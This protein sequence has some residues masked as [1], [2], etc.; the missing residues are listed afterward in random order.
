M[1]R[2]NF[3]GWLLHEDN[4]IDPFR[5]KVGLDRIRGKNINIAISMNGMDYEPVGNIII[6]HDC[7]HPCGIEVA[8]GTTT[9]AKV[10]RK[11]SHVLDAF[12]LPTLD[13]FGE[14]E[15]VRCWK[16]VAVT[17][18]HMLRE[19]LSVT[20]QHNRSRLLRN[21]I[22]IFQKSPITQQLGVEGVREVLMQ[23][24]TSYYSSVYTLTSTVTHQEIL[25]HLVT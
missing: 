19:G 20:G 23:Y 17:S 10:L 8:L 21:Y 5:H 16:D 9:V 7:F 3:P 12:P 2:L 13:S 11:F 22:S 6:Y 14:P 4:E 1:A 15:V 25:D 24:L 18:L